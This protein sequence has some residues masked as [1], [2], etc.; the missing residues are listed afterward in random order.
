M[1]HFFPR[2]ASINL[3]SLFQCT[4]ISSVF[5]YSTKY[6]PRLIFSIDIAPPCLVLM[7]LVLLKWSLTTSVLNRVLPLLF[8]TFELLLGWSVFVILHNPQSIPFPLYISRF[9]FQSLHL[10]TFLDQ[11]S[12]YARIYF[13]LAFFL[14]LMNLFL[15]ILNVCTDSNYEFRAVQCH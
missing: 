11:R 2:K 3:T 6:V 13:P 5:S 9:K 1:G 4:N 14:K 15:H 7:S 12:T 8:H 10:L